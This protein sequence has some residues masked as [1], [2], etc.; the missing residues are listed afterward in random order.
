VITLYTRA[1]CHLCDDAE[2]ALERVRA[3]VPFDLEVVDV[4]G[5]PRLAELYGWEVPVILVDG[6][7]FAK[8]RLDEVAL[9][10]RLR[11]P[12]PGGAGER[13]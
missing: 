6:K 13:A 2:A 11:A 12:R 5:D 7:K 8:Y 10:R 3:R 1:G 9:E 4:D